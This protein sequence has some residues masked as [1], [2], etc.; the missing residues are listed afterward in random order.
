MD[1]LKQAIKYIRE[2]TEMLDGCT[3]LKDKT[4]S[5]QNHQ[6]STLIIASNGKLLHSGRLPFTSVQSFQKS[7][8]RFSVKNFV[9]GSMNYKSSGRIY[10]S[11]CRLFESTQIER[12]VCNRSAKR[13]K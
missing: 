2:L 13:V 7:S 6:P 9:A 3:P 1:T 11:F 5:M 12:R 8:W 4:E 10:S